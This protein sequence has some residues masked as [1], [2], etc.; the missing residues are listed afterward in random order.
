MSFA[1]FESDNDSYGIPQKAA[2]TSF[3]SLDGEISEPVSSNRDLKIFSRY[4]SFKRKREDNISR[5]P[6]KKAQQRPV[7]RQTTLSFPPKEISKMDRSNFNGQPLDASP[8]SSSPSHSRKKMEESFITNHEVALRT[9]SGISFEKTLTTLTV[10]E[11]LTV[12]LTL[13]E[14]A[15][16]PSPKK[17]EHKVLSLVE[18]FG[19]VTSVLTNQEG[20]PPGCIL[21]T[22]VDDHYSEGIR[23]ITWTHMLPSGEA[24]AGRSYRFIGKMGLFQHQKVMKSLWVEQISSD[25]C[26]YLR[27]ASLSKWNLEE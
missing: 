20:T 22:V 2:R 26:E 11:A 23:V 24:I 12:K 27:G 14:K 13:D 15:I 8:L 10:D 5:P 25:E 6:P 21:L 3:Y 18:L 9:V 16:L 4:D 19:I 1:E 7:L 17:D